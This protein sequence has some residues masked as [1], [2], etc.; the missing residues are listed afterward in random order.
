MGGFVSPGRVG[1]VVVGDF[2]GAA[3]GTPVGLLDVGRTV[4][5]VEG[6]KLGWVVG[7]D[8]GCLLGCLVGCELG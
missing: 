1:A 4:G 6:C 5:C 3:E 7:C 2:E 8:V